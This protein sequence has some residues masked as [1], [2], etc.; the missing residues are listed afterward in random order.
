MPRQSS[1]THCPTAATDSSRTCVLLQARLRWM[2]ARRT[3][4]ST[5]DARL[6][7]DG[8]PATSASGPFPFQP[9]SRS[10]TDGALLRRVDVFRLA[11]LEQ[12]RL[13]VGHEEFLRRLIPDVEA[14]VVDERRL[15]LE[16]LIPADP[17]DRL[18]YPLA[19]LVAER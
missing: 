4:Q 13:H 2:R 12:E 16:P 11:R 6:P 9:V 3:W 15:E 5:A 7:A 19:Q 18:V 14:V 10:P 1:A 8:P 17:A